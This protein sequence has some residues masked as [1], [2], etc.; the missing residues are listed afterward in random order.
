MPSSFE[1]IAGKLIGSTKGAQV[2]QQTNSKE[3][4]TINA[5]CGK[6]ITSAVN[7]KSDLRLQIFRVINNKVKKGDIIVA[8]HVGGAPL[9][10]VEV[11]PGES[12]DGEF[13]MAFVYHGTTLVS[14]E[15]NFYVIK[16][17]VIQ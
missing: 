10:D 11:K 12:K 17:G 16:G 15:I 1:A 2:T 4:V 5:E 3:A 9:G 7:G 8:N 6:I 14:I 13:S